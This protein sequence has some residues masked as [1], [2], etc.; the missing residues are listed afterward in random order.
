M[1]HLEHLISKVNWVNFEINSV[2]PSSFLVLSKKVL[3]CLFTPSRQLSGV[4]EEGTWS[5]TSPSRTS[6]SVSICCGSGPKALR[7]AWDFHIPHHELNPSVEKVKDKRAG[8]RPMSSNAVEEISS[9]LYKLVKVKVTRNLSEAKLL[10]NCHRLVKFIS[11]HNDPGS[12]P[13][14]WE[15]TRLNHE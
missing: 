5:N 8:M 15:E 10:G 4:N 2:L 7:K 12:A 3:T 9:V 14:N 11:R 6:Y 1:D 13:T